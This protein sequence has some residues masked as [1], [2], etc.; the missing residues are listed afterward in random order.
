[1]GYVSSL[2][3]VAYAH[4]CKNITCEI[5]NYILIHCTYSC[6]RAKDWWIIIKMRKS[7]KGEPWGVLLADLIPVNELYPWWRETKEI[8]SYLK[9][10]HDPFLRS[11]IQLQNHLTSPSLPKLGKET[12]TVDYQSIW[13][14]LAVL[15]LTFLPC[16]NTKK[17]QGPILH[18]REGPAKSQTT[19]VQD[20]VMRVTKG[21]IPRLV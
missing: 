15:M 21:R 6:K 20:H 11:P 7:C 19:E 10:K 14:Q 9:S 4:L 13:N 3:G 8:W 1:M 16:G 12:G 17:E 18:L 2:E 5:L